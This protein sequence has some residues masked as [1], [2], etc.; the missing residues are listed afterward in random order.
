MVTHFVT[1]PDGKQIAYDLSGTGPA[2]ILL[3]GGGGSRKEWH[4][5]GYVSWLQ[6]RF[7]VVA[8][9]LRGHGESS[10]PVEPADYSIDKLRRDILEVAD[11]C[12]VERFS[13][14]AMSHGGR[15]ARYLATSSARVNSIVLMSTLLGPGASGELRQEVVDFC[16]HWPPILEG[17]RNGSLD[18]ASL[19]RHDQ[20]FMHAFN[21]PAMLGWGRAMLDW[22][23]VEPA[24]FLCPALWLVGSEDRRAMDSFKEFEASLAG[25]LVKAQILEGLSHDQVFDEIN[26]VFPIML[27]FTLAQLDRDKKLLRN[28]PQVWNLLEVLPKHNGMESN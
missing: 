26:R 13:L 27:E 8:L 21:I 16:A 1:S 4:E 23:A 28:L 6:D 11:D 20:E 22:P 12:G 24:E 5:A 15:I 25:S 3:H 17:Q 9:D 2:I 10:L 14:W 7:T 18:L 19:S